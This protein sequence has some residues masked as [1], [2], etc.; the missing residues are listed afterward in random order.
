M[1][2]G[3][4]SVSA[5]I[6]STPHQKEYLSSMMIPFP[7]CTA[8]PIKWQVVPDLLGHPCDALETRVQR[9][10]TI[11]HHFSLQRDVQLPLVSRRLCGGC[12]P[13]I[14]PERTQMTKRIPVSHVP[15]HI[16]G[17]SSLGCVG[18]A[19]HTDVSVALSCL[20]PAREFFT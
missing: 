20:F 8:S 19:L 17:F 14:H 7:C 1:E 6:T 9:L 16:D 5:G 12:M 4:V 2:G 18:S 13:R 15:G 11:P 10:T 3:I